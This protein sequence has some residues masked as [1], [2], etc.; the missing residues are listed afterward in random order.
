MNKGFFGFCSFNEVWQTIINL[1]IFTSHFWLTIITFL[2]T[3]ITTYI[4]ES[5]HAYYTLIFLLMVDFITGVAKGIKFKCF[6]SRK[7]SRIVVILIAYTSLLS[8][9]FNLAKASVVYF[10]L[11]NLIF[12]L[13]TSTALISIVE[14]L[15]ELGILKKDLIDFIKSKVSL[16]N[17]LKKK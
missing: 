5:T 15:G 7:F 17:L 2:S 10:F 1:K 8:I 3:F 9:A 16:K 6:S 13:L 14:N 4:W 11:P 12:T